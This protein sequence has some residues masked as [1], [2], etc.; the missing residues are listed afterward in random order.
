MR[1]SGPLL[2]GGRAI[3]RPGRPAA[4]LTV[5]IAA[6]LAGQAGLQAADID[7]APCIECHGDGA[8]APATPETPTLA[9]LSEVYA[10]YQLVYFRLGQRKNEIMGP[11]TEG[12][13]D[14]ELRGFATWIGTL[15]PP[16]APATPP[17][18]ALFERGADLVR[19]HRCTNCHEPD[20]SGREHM[21]RLAGQQE[22][23]LLQALRDYKSGERVGIQAAMAEVLSPMTDED[24]QALAHFM[25]HAVR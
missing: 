22:T 12:M 25:A 7:P 23:Y 18:P 10:L 6:L 19:N 21:P 15:P 14:D 4:V 5:A 16:K 2:R 1:G 24:L 11:L 13:S 17:D 8:R 20:L 3:F 9:G